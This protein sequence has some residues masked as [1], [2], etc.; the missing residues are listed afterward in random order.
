MP[1]QLGMV[2]RALSPDPPWSDG[3]QPLRVCLRAAELESLE[4]GSRVLLRVREQD[5][6]WLN[7][8]RPM[9][10]QERLRVVLWVDEATL[11]PLLRRAVDLVDWVSRSHEV[12]PRRWPVFAEHGMRSA[13]HHGVPV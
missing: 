5:I 4:P 3:P 12:P 11:D 2:V 7:L 13:L 9:F 1:T 10:D 8:V 6:E